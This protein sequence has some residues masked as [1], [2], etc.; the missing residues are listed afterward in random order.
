MDLRY[1]GVPGRQAMGMFHFS[2]MTIRGKLIV[3][4]MGITVGVL[5]VASA[6]SIG[7]DVVA[8]R[9]DTTEQL[10][11]LAEFIGA[12]N[13]DALVAGDTDFSNQALEEL[14]NQNNI[15]FAC[16]YTPQGWRFA[17]YQRGKDSPACARTAEAKDAARLELH[18]IVVSHEIVQGGRF[19]GTI[20]LASSTDELWTNLR[21]DVEFSLAILITLSLAAFLFA[22]RL[23]ETISFPIRSLAWTAKLVSAQKDYTIRAT[24]K[25]G[26]EIAAL[27]EGFND[28]L[29]QLGRQ[30]GE[31]R[32]RRHD[33]EL[34]VEERTVALQDEIT[35]RE[36][37]EK[38]LRKSEER[39]R[40]L[41]DSTEE[42]IY[43]L[44]AE[45]H[46]TFCNPA[47]VRLLGYK[48]AVEILGRK[49]HLLVH[50]SYPDG[51]P[52]PES[53]CPIAASLNR[54]EKT[55]SEDEQFWRANRTSFPVEYWA[56]PILQDGKA[57][58]AV[59]SFLD[60]TERRAAQE[61][62]QRAT[63]AA[64]A[65]NRAKSEFLAN[66]SHEIRTPM[67]GI[68]GMTELALDTPLNKEQREYLQ[69]VRGSA[70]SLLR[71]VNDILDFSKIEA[72]QFDIE[73]VEFDL[74][75]LLT[76]T[77]KTLAVRAHQKGLE[78]TSRIAPG[79]P[80]AVVSD[81][82]RLRQVLVN[83]LGNAIKFTEAGTVSLEVGTESSGEDRTLLHFVV[84]DTGI[85]ISADKLTLVFEPFAQADGSMT[86]RYGGTGLGLTI[87]KRVVELLGGRIWVASERSV[88]SAFQFTMQFDHARAAADE[89]APKAKCLEDL[90]VLVVD[91]NDT[92]RLILDEMLKNWKM[93]PTLADGG[94]A[95]LA[96]MR[97]ARDA[98]RS[99]PLVL[100]DAHMPGMDGFAVAEQIQKDPSLSGA[101][102]MM[103][104]SDRNLGDSERCQELGIKLCLVKP[105]G[106]SELL[107]A[108]LGVMGSAAVI[109]GPATG[110]TQAPK[111][112]PLRILVA[113]DNAVNL[114]LVQRLLERRGHSVTIAT[115]GKEAL[116]RLEQHGYTAFDA[117]LMDVQMPGMDGIEAVEEIRKR[118]NS[119]GTHLPIIGVTAHAM[120]G[121]RERCLRAGM[122]GYV[123][124]P[125]QVEKL[126]DELDRL[127]S[128]RP[129]ALA[130][131]ET[132]QPTATPQAFDYESALERVEGDAELLNDL[133][134]IFLD[135]LP[136]QSSALHK[137]VEAQDAIRIEHEAHRLKGAAGSL[138]AKAVAECAARLE[139]TCRG[140]NLAAARSDWNLLETEIARLEPVLRELHPE[141]AR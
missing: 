22:S 135:D 54:G 16:L 130:A 87:S 7:Y 140:K 102:I 59:V 139:A 134:G 21:W 118:E 14:Q 105:I 117:V 120:V 125:I 34:R 42:A 1:E 17:F 64:E 41:L 83:L 36:Q 10:K 81:P 96:A 43:G 109:K 5:A 106:R 49:M 74:A 122:D 69:L 31:L 71:I 127:T 26:G 28:M 35:V 50:H 73:K 58:G 110:H 19:F 38:A 101:T 98:G 66:M 82:G 68:L 138:G 119:L 15:L 46:C 51:R 2:R 11:A 60:I 61:A 27:F 55:H 24:S 90:P 25:A 92:N 91:D 40:L 116:D 44:D 18:R 137:A 79:V 128:D 103:L 121:Y 30:D 94:E 97:W 12:S 57:A 77:V 33:L 45:G 56:H 86:R 95:A 76:Q 88:G 3:I 8:Y 108:I 72:G 52:Y 13:A 62:L 123:T 53:D 112:R 4:I 67:N 89:S 32:Q 47:T 100:L 104:T 126:F 85:G 9:K 107:D 29:E 63:V 23:Q 93:Q 136:N 6:A 99:F 84:R 39:A 141:A 20:V 48:E 37:A 70:D 113:E 124:K 133:I 111:S 114:H 75:E 80:R 129:V 65:A 132:S 131:P 115:N 78:L